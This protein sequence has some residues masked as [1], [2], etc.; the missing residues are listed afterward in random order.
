[1]RGH[2]TSPMAAWRLARR[3]APSWV[4]ALEQTIWSRFSPG[5]KGLR[6]TPRLPRRRP[7]TGAIPG[8]RAPRFPAAVSGDKAG[9]LGAALA[10]DVKDA[11]YE[12]TVEYNHSCKV[13][14][15]AVPSAL[16]GVQVGQLLDRRRSKVD[17]DREVV[18]AGVSNISA[19]RKGAGRYDGR[20]NV[21]SGHDRI[22]K[23]R[24]CLH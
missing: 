21:G 17:T 13:R 2:E 22:K 18:K 4:T 11:A 19:H 15:N 7:H 16:V 24:L 23:A 10:M 3:R 9:E 1:M 6:P 20:G 8:R 5:Y 12:R 14:G